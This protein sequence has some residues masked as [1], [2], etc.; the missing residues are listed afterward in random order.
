ME[1]MKLMLGVIPGYGHENKDLTVDNALRVGTEEWIKAT[2]EVAQMQSDKDNPESENLYQINGTFVPAMAVYSKGFGCPEGGEVGIQINAEMAEGQDPEVFRKSVMKTAEV[3]MA[4]LGQSTT[5]IEWSSDEKAAGTSYLSE[6]GKKVSENSPSEVEIE[7][8]SVTLGDGSLSNE[9]YVR[10]G[11]A[12]QAAMNIVSQTPTV[13]EDEEA[14][15]YYMIS[16]VMTPGENGVS[17]GASQN[18]MYGQTDNNLYKKSVQKTV[19][20]AMKT[21]GQTKAEIDFGAEKVTVD[22]EAKQEE[23]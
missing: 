22:L 12:I 1:K 15:D 14:G 11:S 23:R 5:T 16:G 3:A 21:L 19:E 8:F 17:F 6:G 9:E 4:K 20:M 13:Q 2:E 10:V 18:P 7:R